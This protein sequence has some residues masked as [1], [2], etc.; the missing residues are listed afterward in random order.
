MI[1]LNDLVKLKHEPPPMYG[2]G[3]PDRQGWIGIV[4]GVRHSA[5][6][7]TAN[8]LWPQIGDVERWHADALEVISDAS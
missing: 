7:Q 8:V 1:H 4:V 3:Q 6:S 5:V 2:T